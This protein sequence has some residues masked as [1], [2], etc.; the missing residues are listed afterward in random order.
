MVETPHAERTGE[1]ILVAER[2]DCVFPVI[3]RFEHVSGDFWT[4]STFWLATDSPDA[5]Q[6]VEFQYG[7]SGK[8]SGFEMT[9]NSRDGGVSEGTVLFERIE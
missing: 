9:I 3:W 8:P 5:F 6:A 2:P 1:T 4:A 7:I